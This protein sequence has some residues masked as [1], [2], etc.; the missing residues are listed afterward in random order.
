MGKIK[1]SFSLPLF[2]ELKEIPVQEVE[3]K[4]F[5][6]VSEYNEFVS[7]NGE[8]KVKYL[9]DWL[10][11]DK[12]MIRSISGNTVG[13]G[14]IIFFAQK[15]KFKSGSFASLAIQQLN[16]EEIEGFEKLIEERKEKAKESE[17]RMEIV[18]IK[19]DILEIKYKK[20]KLPALWTIEKFLKGREKNYLVSFLL[21]EK[22]LKA[23][24]QEID[25]IFTSIE[26][27]Q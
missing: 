4:L 20:E 8:L 7:P 6:E 17:T 14:E 13:E 11:V 19:E 10:E 26:I 18:K 2:S 5:G 23:F 25:S 21:P 12:E 1:K 16:K 15:I 3:N 27:R 24:R 22:D 9:A